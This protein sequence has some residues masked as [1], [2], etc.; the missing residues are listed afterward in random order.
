MVIQYILLRNY[1]RKARQKYIKAIKN[2]LSIS[3]VYIF[4]CTKIIPVTIN[5]ATV[6]D[7]EAD[8]GYGISSGIIL[9]TYDG[10]FPE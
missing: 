8:L 10:C 1:K 5:E 4:I 7:D 9:L 3:I 2:R 6:K